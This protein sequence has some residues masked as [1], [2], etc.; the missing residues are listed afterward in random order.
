MTASAQPA[1]LIWATR[2]HSWGF[3]FLFD[4]GFDDPLREYEQAFTGL[5]DAPT[6]WRRDGKRVALR[7]PDPEG[8]RDSSGRVIPHEFVLFGEVADA[9]GSVDEGLE[10][11]WP[12]VDR[13]YDRIWNADTAPNAEDLRF[14]V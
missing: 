14:D 12:L 11:I 7:F 13:V 5:S 6:A 3:R 2:G 1:E 4:A 9:I 10:E 8:R